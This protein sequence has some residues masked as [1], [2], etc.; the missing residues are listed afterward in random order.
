M[1]MRSDTKRVIAREWLYLILGFL[2]G[3][4]P[5]PL[6]LYLFLSPDSYTLSKFYLDLFE[7]LFSGRGS[8]VVVV[9]LVMLAPY[10]LFQFG[11]SE[12]WA[13]GVV[14]SK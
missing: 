12:K 14:R 7:A 9:I 4:G 2:V 13:L 1:D 5:V 11:R 3:L 6:F 10:L 8:E